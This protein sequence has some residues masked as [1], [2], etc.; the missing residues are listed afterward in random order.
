M[1]FA[2][3]RSLWKPLLNKLLPTASLGLGVTIFMFAVTYVP[4]AA[5]LTVFNGPLAILTTILLVRT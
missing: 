4:Q 3:H 1:Y 5:I 2:S